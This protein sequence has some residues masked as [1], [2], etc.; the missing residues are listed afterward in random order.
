MLSSAQLGTAASVVSLGQAVGA[1]TWGAAADSIGR[2]RAFLGSLILT[3]VFGLGSCAAVGFYSF[4]ALRLLTG[5]AI[6]GNLPLAV[7]IVSEMLPPNRREQSIV[8]LQMF[9]EVPSRCL[10]PP[11]F[12]RYASR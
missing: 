1:A 6:G 8:A 9:N 12:S 7:S 5:F 2:R 3:I 4:C 10:P 11:P